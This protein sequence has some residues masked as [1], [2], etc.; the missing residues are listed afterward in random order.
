MNRADKILATKGMYEKQ[1]LSQ[2]ADAID[3]INTPYERQSMRGYFS[4]KERCE[5]IKKDVMQGTYKGK[6]DKDMEEYRLHIL[7]EMEE[8]DDDEKA[9]DLLIKG[10]GELKEHSM[11][12]NYNE[13]YKKFCVI[14]I[15]CNVIDNM[16]TKEVPPEVIRSYFPE[17]LKEEAEV[18]AKAM[19]KGIEAGL[20]EEVFA[21]EYGV[22][23]L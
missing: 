10:A 14:E 13:Q 9:L 20:K 19:K 3:I 5:E 11:A 22:F 12:L 8:E 7:R 16:V 23:S 17:E 1:T 4:A 18:I 6:T 15:M 2:I 21:C